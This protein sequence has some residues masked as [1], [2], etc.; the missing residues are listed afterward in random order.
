MIPNGTPYDNYPSFANSGTRTPPGGSTESAKYA[1]GMVPADTFPAEWANWLFH[2]ATA[3]ITRLNTDTASIKKELNTLLSCSGMTG[4]ADCYSQVYEAIMSRI[5][6]C[7]GVRAPEMHAT[8]ESCYGVGNSSCY[9]HLKISDTYTSVLSSCAGVAASQ[10]AVACVYG[11]A[12]GKPG[13]G[14]TAGCALGTAAAGTA[15]TAARSDHVHPKPTLSDLG[16]APTSHASA[17]TTYGAAT[18][19]D[20]GHVKLS[21]SYTS[22]AGAAADGIAASS[23][24]VYAAY[25]AARNFGNTTAFNKYECNA[26]GEAAAADCKVTLGC[27]RSYRWSGATTNVCSFD[28]RTYAKFGI[29]QTQNACSGYAYIDVCSWQCCYSGT[30]GCTTCSTKKFYFKS[31]GAICADQIHAASSTFGNMLRTCRTGSCNMASISFYNCNGLLGHIAMGGAVNGNLKRYKNDNSTSYDIYDS[32]MT[33]PIANGG[34]GAKCA[35]DARTCLGLG[36]AATCAAGCFLAKTGCAADS[37]KLGGCPASCFLT[38]SPEAVDCAYSVELCGYNRTLKAKWCVFCMPGG[39]CQCIQLAVC[40]NLPTGQCLI[41]LPSNIFSL[42]YQSNGRIGAD[43]FIDDVADS[44]KRV[45]SCYLVPSSSCYSPACTS[46]CNI[47]FIKTF[48]K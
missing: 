30:A 40:Y 43:V 24:A 31:D 5:N 41:G 28:R 16:A 32:S 15:T 12:N 2:G 8:A 25:T 18:A 17:D 39:T 19:T 33:I 34:T 44:W 27:S 9:G 47:P 4:S 6:A 35:A 21:N 45:G 38:S 10:K 37:A 36:T 23:C 22:S 1:L 13:L 42:C 7:T 20:Y 48:K 46:C 29:Y 3:G 14:S 26:S 11:V